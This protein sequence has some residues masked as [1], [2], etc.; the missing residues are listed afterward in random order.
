MLVILLPKVEH[1]GKCA[2][3]EEAAENDS[4]G[5]SGVCAERKGLRV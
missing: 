2:L 5:K 3:E 1:K 4:V